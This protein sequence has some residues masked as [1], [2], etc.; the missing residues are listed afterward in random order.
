MKNAL[1][2]DCKVN[3]TR[4]YYEKLFTTFVGTNWLKKYVIL[5]NVE[6][7]QIMISYST[8]GRPGSVLCELWTAAPTS[9]SCWF[10]F[11]PTGSGCRRPYQKPASSCFSAPFEPH[12]LHEERPLGNVEPL[13]FNLV[14]TLQVASEHFGAIAQLVGRETLMKKPSRSI[15]NKILHRTGTSRTANSFW[16]TSGRFMAV[17]DFLQRMF[18]LSR[19]WPQSYRPPSIVMRGRFHPG[20]GNRNCTEKYEIRLQIMG[21]TKIFKLVHYDGLPWRKF[22]QQFIHVSSAKIAPPRSF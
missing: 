17:V 22:P 10:C 16:C 8:A 19:G 6:M 18:C 2:N 13:S 5:M 11:R 1:F 9:R 20:C 21:E 12:S 14:E 15:G 4:S 3:V 7:L